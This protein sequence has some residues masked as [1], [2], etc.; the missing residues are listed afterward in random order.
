MVCIYCCYFCDIDD[1]GEEEVYVD[2]G[3]VGS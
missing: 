1:G 2:N 3:G